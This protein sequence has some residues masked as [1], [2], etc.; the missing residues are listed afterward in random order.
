M[1]EATARDGA[2]QQQE[3]LTMTTP[4]PGGLF[5]GEQRVP[6]LGVSIE[7]KVQGMAATLNVAQR[8][9]ND[10]AV[11]VE[12]VYSFP[13]PESAAV[14]G[15]EVLVGE[16]R[17]V[18]RVEEKEKAFDVYDE[19]MGNRQGA[20]LLDQDRPN[21][22]SASVGNLLPGQELVV[23]LKVVTEVEQRG[24]ELRLLIPTTIAPRYVP[25]QMAASADPSELAHINPPRVVGS[26][27]YG[28]EL[29]VDLELAAE[30][31]SLQCPSHPASV[32]LRSATE[33]RVE[34]MGQDVQL[35][36]DFVLS[37]R[38]RKPHEPSALVARHK[39]GGRVVML[40]VYPDL[41]GLARTP[42]EVVFLLD[43]SGSMRGESMQQAR[44]ALQLC[45]RSLEE[46]DRFNIVGF[47]S[48]FESL[49]PASSAY[50][51]ATL[52]VATAHLQQVRA[53]LG[54]TELMGPLQA[55]FAAP[56][57]GELTRQ[58]VLLTD[59]E[60]ANEAA[61][62]DLVRRHSSTTRV[63]TF[64]I[65]S[66][67]SEYLV[68]GLA[69]AS[70]GAAELI[71][72]NER[73]EPTVLR[74]FARV[75]TPYLSNV[76]MD[77]GGL[78]VDLV[79]PHK[80]PA[81]YPG[82]RVT[83][84]ARL[85]SGGA[86]EVA[87]MANGPTGELRFGVNVDPERA[88]DDL[89]VVQLMARRAI[90]DL[91][92]GRSA[93]HGSG[94]SQQ[95]ERRARRVRDSIVELGVRYGLMSSATSFVAV[96]KRDGAQQTADA[97]LRRVPIALTK[98]WGA[99]DRQ[100]PRP[101]PATSFTRTQAGTIGSYAPPAPI[102]AAAMPPGGPAERK[103]GVVAGAV[104][105]L[106]DLFGGGGSQGGSAPSASAPPAQSYGLASP[107]LPP[108]VP[109]AHRKRA[110]K[111]APP[112]ERKE[113]SAARRGGSRQSDPLLELSLAQRADGSWAANAALAAAAGSDLKTLTRA[114]AQ[115]GAPAELASRIVATLAA[116][117]ALR[118]RW[119]GREVEWRLLAGKAERWLRAQGV[120]APGGQPDL[121]TWIAEVLG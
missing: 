64:G 99:Q 8:Y 75:A 49:F 23:R 10:E 16:D 110:R 40:S 93:L 88:L 57:V 106:S 20:F 44:A 30:I 89:G 87:L 72:P 73:I 17:I 13:L 120:Q 108:S 117:H 92:E 111:A 18:G 27:P 60:V 66:G 38:L 103:G 47:G 59:G 15:F 82:D 45:L 29:S 33:A 58:V 37:A 97:A 121:E 114:A 2:E 19:A 1:S 11:P 68:R 14:G 83:V 76:R 32:S 70:G 53:N 65:G 43:R 95:K 90:Q 116:L 81:L 22:F 100:R 46:G 98:G 112:R 119:P 41:A 42:T 50:T 78:D 26:V 91:E 54:G 85:R 84:F 113:R 5:H 80:L 51:Q 28:L 96:H 94:G 48:R 7:A 63:F 25:R 101:V 36:R 34:L 3:E 9:R 31:E 21:V 12:A 67:P 86:G 77:W 107:A 109:R 6:L 105:F 55:I 62:I 79:A 102:P 74:Q 69:R 24:Q 35:D 71:H 4:K 61:C 118:T 52:D 115:L 104:E 39:D 56:P